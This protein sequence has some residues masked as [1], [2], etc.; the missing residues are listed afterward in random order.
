MPAREVGQCGQRVVDR[1]QRCGMAATRSR[2]ER[3][4]S[5]LQSATAD[6][7]RSR[8]VGTCLNQEVVTVVTLAAQ[9][10]KQTTRL[11]ASRV[12]LHSST[13]PVRIEAVN[14]LPV[15]CGCQ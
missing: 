10:P 7:C 15:R 9:C 4:L 8:A 3:F 14:Q 13:Q 5:L 2:L 6:D 11:D 12:N 1:D